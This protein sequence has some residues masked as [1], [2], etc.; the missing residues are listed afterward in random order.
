MKKCAIYTRVSTD[1]QAEK[2]FNSCETQE[3]KIKSFIDSQ[4]D[5]TVYD[6]YSDPG[7]SGGSTNRPDLQRLLGDI[8]V[9]KIDIIISYKIDRLTRS[10]KDFY[11]MIELFEEYGV[12]FIS[13]TERFDTSTP[14][15][16]LLRNIM[17]TFAQFERELSSER[18]KDKLLQR[19]EQGMWNGGNIPYGYKS[20]DKQLV[21][22]KDQSKIIKDIF[23]T[24]LEIRC[25][26]TIHKKVKSE[27]NLSKS[28]VAYILKNPVYTGKIKY[29]GNIYEGAHQAI[30]SENIFN[31]VQALFSKKVKRYRTYKN[32]LFAGFIKCSEC[33][34]LMTPYHVNKHSK[35]KMKHYY[36]YRC[37]KTF[38]HDW[39]SCGTKQINADRLE[40]YIFS[41]LNDISDDDFYINALVRMNRREKFDLGYQEGL[42]LRES[43][44]DLAE[45]MLKKHLKK[46]IKTI[47]KHLK[48]I[49]KTIQTQGGEERS[50]KIKKLISLIEY[51]PEEI[52]IQLKNISLLDS[53]AELSTSPRPNR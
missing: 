37:T 15:G 12:D 6:V 36:Y 40:Q 34:S 39:E 16:R 14:S 45:K 4:E 29:N 43:P 19:A 49:I 11:Q 31:K 24:Y 41:K 35:G 22:D 26:S 42:E 53:S 3:L 10:P 33:G 2:F 25:I 18:T 48:K 28:Q 52:K 44:P 47:K 5:L 51:S 13:V 30:I 50:L 46:I 7:Y 1:N 32:H 9:N 23:N 27:S 21:P 8:K 20:I 38:K 17:L